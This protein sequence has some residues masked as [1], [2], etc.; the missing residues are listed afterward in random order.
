M[1]AKPQFLF[2]VFV[3]VTLLVITAVTAQVLA[4]ELP[5]WDS[6]RQFLS[7]GRQGAPQISPD[8]A[9]SAERAGPALAPALPNAL[10]YE[11]QIVSVVERSTASVVSII[12]TKDLP[13][14]ERY[15]ID[16]FDGFGFPGFEFQI[17]Q[18]RERGTQRQEVGGG[19]GF[20]ISDNG[21]IL[22]NN[23]VV[24]DPEAEY[25]VFLND[26]TKL[27]GRVIGRDA[28]L[29]VAIIQVDRVGLAALP[30]GD[31]DRLRLGQAAIAIGNA[32]GE[33]RN[34]VSTGVISG[35]GRTITAFDGDQVVTF[36][37]VIQ[38]DAAINRGNSGGPLLNL[39]GEVIGVN[40]A[41]ARGAE[42]IGFAI[43][44]NVVKR[45]IEEVKATGRIT[46][47]FLGIHYRMVN[48]ALARA[49]GLP[50]AYGAWLVPNAAGLATLPGSPA[51]NAGLRAR[52]LITEVNDQSLAGDNH[53]ALVLRQYRPGNTITLRVWR[54]GTGWMEIRVTLGQA[55][56]QM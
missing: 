14:L 44:I 40:T 35:L 11:E 9:I 4:F 50:V 19:T 3:V 5:R 30:L 56:S 41:M 52:D 53:L 1:K 2:L 22:T 46:I 23:H 25:T 12:V 39:R 32:L 27:P 29:D 55:P 38:T 20:I 51:A 36:S 42:N 33:F 45:I 24:A 8:P 48:E 31:S 47:P 6:L 15:F 26:G 43:P 54:A 28:T 18:Y 37:N 17:P 16:P 49:E 10:A 13:V 21:F 34:T 7:P